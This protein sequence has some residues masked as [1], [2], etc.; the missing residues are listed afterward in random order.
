MRKISVRCFEPQTLLHLHCLVST[1]C[2]SIE[3]C[4]ELGVCAQSYQS[5]CEP[6][7]QAQVNTSPPKLMKHPYPTSQVTHSRK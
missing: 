6:T 3:Y 7:L 2:Q 5:M 4:T 1:E